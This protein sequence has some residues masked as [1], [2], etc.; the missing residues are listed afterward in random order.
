VADAAAI[1]PAECPEGHALEDRLQAGLD[2]WRIHYHLHEA[3]AE[4]K[5]P[6]AVELC[7]DQQVSV[8][9]L[10]LH[11]LRAHLNKLALHPGLVL[12]DLLCHKRV[13]LEVVAL[14]HFQPR[15]LLFVQRM[16]HFVELL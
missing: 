5:A 11:V 8:V 10:G 6:V 15:S 1:V 9:E 13:R 2:A 7:V 16:L 3:R 4:V 12:L 14:Q